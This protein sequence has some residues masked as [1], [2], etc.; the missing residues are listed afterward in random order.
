MLT[1]AAMPREVLGCVA[2]ETAR[3]VILDPTDN[4]FILDNLDRD[5]MIEPLDNVLPGGVQVR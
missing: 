5:P 2:A 4:F 3:Q 1:T